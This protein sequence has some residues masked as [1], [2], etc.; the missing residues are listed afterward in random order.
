MSNAIQ[1][2]EAIKAQEEKFR[3]LDKANGALLD[4]EREC[5]F[6]R[7][8]ILKNDFTLKI[9]GQNPNSLQAA[10]LN[11][12]SIGVSLNP[13]SSHAY[14]VPRD[15]RIC[16]DISFRGLVYL[17]TDSGA[18]RW[19]KAELVREADTFKW[20]GPTSSPIHEADVF[21]TDRGEVIGGYVIAGLP[22]GTEMVEIMTIAEINKVRDTSKSYQKSSGPWVDWPDEMAKKTLIKRAYKSWPQTPGRRRL[23][24]AVE[25]LH[26]SEG[27]RYT[28]EQQAA[29]LEAI[30]N[31]D[32]L[33]ILMMRREL[34]NE[35]FA[36]LF[37]SFEKGTKTKQKNI[38][39]QLE[40]K[41]SDMLQGYA[42][43]LQSLADASDDHGI[44]EIL[45]ELPPSLLESVRNELT[46]EANEYLEQLAA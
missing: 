30:K 6:A 28:L 45:E 17:A 2:V 24:S 31:E 43:D 19:A 13:A 14:L 46:P 21:K 5:L 34:G 18:I 8:Q 1:I 9:A 11:V 44:A 3:S 7:Q 10:I 39:R 29:F 16:L 41:G 25:A 20:C 40:M 23:D 38:V 4:F 15:G 22:D 33:G 27:M 12:A 26:D 42:V 32:A 36:S 37:N 35:T